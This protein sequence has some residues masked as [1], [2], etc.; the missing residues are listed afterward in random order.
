MNLT[1]AVFMASKLK[2]VYIKERPIDDRCPKRLVVNGQYLYNS[3][4]YKYTAN[5]PF[6]PS[7]EDF[8]S[9]WRITG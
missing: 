5:S 1:D 8:T 7:I 9:E 3:S 4:G 6:I 2:K